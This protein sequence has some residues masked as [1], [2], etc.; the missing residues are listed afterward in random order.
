MVLIIS[1]HEIFF[2]YSPRNTTWNLKIQICSFYIFKVINNNIGLDS[3]CLE[4][5]V[6][7]LTKYRLAYSLLGW[8]ATVSF[9][10]NCSVHFWGLETLGSLSVCK[11][12][13][14]HL[15]LRLVDSNDHV[16]HTWGWYNTLSQNVYLKI[17]ETYSLI[18]LGVRNPYEG[19]ARLHSSYWFIWRILFVFSEFWWLQLFLRFWYCYPELYASLCGLLC[20]SVAFSFFY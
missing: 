10:I 11:R 17:I 18:V 5:E 20:V 12:L 3:C 7:S 6:L 16:W 2:I 14:L 9:L 4:K 8:V 13:L 19:A 15:F 1:Y